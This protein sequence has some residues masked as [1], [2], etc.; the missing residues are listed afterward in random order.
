M[1]KILS[2]AYEC[3]LGIYFERVTRRLLSFSLE[4]HSMQS[5]KHED[6]A[7]GERKQA[8]VTAKLYSISG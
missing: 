3:N 4:C 5:R 8:E 2:F 6:E 7:R 1:Q